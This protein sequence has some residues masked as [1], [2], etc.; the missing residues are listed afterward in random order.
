ML[1]YFPMALATV[2]VIRAAPLPADARAAKH[3]VDLLRLAKPPQ[4]TSAPLHRV[5]T[6]IFDFALR[7]LL[8]WGMTYALRKMRAQD[9]NQRRPTYRVHRALLTTPLDGE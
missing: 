1:H 6:L 7:L 5:A 4:R 8:C 9:R 2:S 3:T